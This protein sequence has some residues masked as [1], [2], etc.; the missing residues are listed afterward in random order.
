M[1]TSIYENVKNDIFNMFN[2]SQN[3]LEK[4]EL[5]ISQTETTEAIVCILYVVNDEF[6][7]FIHICK[8]R[9]DIEYDKDSPYKIGS[10]VK[11]INPSEPSH[12]YN[13]YKKRF[14]K[15]VVKKETVVKYIE[16]HYNISLNKLKRTIRQTKANKKLSSEIKTDIIDRVKKEII[17]AEKEK[18]YIDKNFDDLDIR[19]S[20]Y[21]K[22][23]GQGFSINYKINKKRCNNRLTNNTPNIFWF[24]ELEEDEAKRSD[25]KQ[26]EYFKKAKRAFGDL[27]YLKKEDYE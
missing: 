18:V 7:K 21:L 23:S 12:N 4:K 8:E 9:L 27:F 19:I 24:K 16:S 22:N 25:E 14:H 5:R 11:L 3:I 17:E 26:M 15:S 1:D 10:I 13:V 20:T 6:M 2:D